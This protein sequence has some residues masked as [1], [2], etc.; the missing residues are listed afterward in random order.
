MKLLLLGCV[1]GT[2]A[3]GRSLLSSRNKVT[4]VPAFD[5]DHYYGTYESISINQG[6]EA[7]DHGTCCGATAPQCKVE[8]ISL[9]GDHWNDHAHNRSRDDSQEGQIVN[10]Y[11]YNGHDDGKQMAIEFNQ[12]V[13][14]YQCV[15]FCPLEGDIPELAINKYALHLGKHTITQDGSSGQTKSVDLYQWTDRIV[16]IPLDQTKFY[17]DESVTPPVPFYQS[18]L[19]EPFGQKIGTENTSYLGFTPGPVDQSK[20]NIVGIKECPKS[21]NCQDNSYTTPARKLAKSFLQLAQDQVDAM[22]DVAVD[23]KADAAK[24]NDL[25]TFPND[26]SAHETAHLVINQGGA[27]DSQGNLCCAHAKIGQ[28][29]VQTEYQSGQKYFDYSNK[30]TRFEDEVSGEIIVNDYTNGKEMAVVHNATLGYDVCTS[31]CPLQ[32]ELDPFAIDPDAKDEGAGTDPITGKAGEHYHWA[33]VILKIIQM[34]HTEFYADISG[35]SALPLSQSEHITPFGGAEIGSSNN[36]WGNFTAGK[37]PAEK[38]DIHGVD[39]CP[40]DPN[41]GQQTKQLRRLMN[42]DYKTFAKYLKL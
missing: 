9:G 28:C 23:A 10:W 2:A 41:C 5:Q 8:V 22:G 27:E 36:T 6:G 17:V 20:F 37:Q 26:W 31:Y 30:R 40:Q 38:F 19:I 32:D 34:S 1:A 4:D 7:T 18:M 15:Q 12:T 14:A 39:E 35:D 11:H 16:V 21:D 25:P 33:D 13:N 3:A 24:P 42:R 29:Q